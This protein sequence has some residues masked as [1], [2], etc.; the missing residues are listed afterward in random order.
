MSVRVHSE[1]FPPP[2]RKA[3]RLR[4]DVSGFLLAVIALL[5]TGYVA[6]SDHTFAANGRVTTGRVL[7]MTRRT[8]RGPD[9]CLV[10][11]TYKG[12][13]GSMQNVSAKVPEGLYD[14]LKVGQ[15]IAVTYLPDEPG[16]SR[17]GRPQD[18]NLMSHYLNLDW[19]PGF[20]AVLIVVGV[21]LGLNSIFSARRDIYLVSHGTAVPGAISEL[22]KDDKTCSASYK[23]KGP[24]GREWTGKRKVDK[25][26]WEGLKE[27]QEV[28]VLYDPA[29][30]K[31][32]GAYPLL[33]AALASEAEAPA[34]RAPVADVRPEQE[35]T[36]KPDVG[37]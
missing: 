5:Y 22:A 17:I 2:P 34:P 11:Y 20:A 16:V 3:R 9:L 7:E 13:S 14:K 33:N 28:V 25:K 31:R 6:Y 18:F 32:H 24:D 30:P 36:A 15:T 35:D 37:Q 27:G 12:V 29:Q 21:L 10:R 26:V 4:R 19:W 23:F 1:Q 8:R